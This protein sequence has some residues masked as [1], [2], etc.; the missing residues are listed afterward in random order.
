MTGSVAVIVFM[1]ATG[2]AM[3]T[4]AAENVVSG[5][6]TSTS[7]VQKLKHEKFKTKIDAKK[8]VLR[9]KMEA[10][11]Q[12]KETTR[13]AIQAALDLGDYSAWLKVVPANSPILTKFYQY[14]ETNELS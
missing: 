8:Q 5:A 1:A 14:R 4:L 13:L 3:T 2:M 12:A 9:A 7:S 10:K 11:K 6:T